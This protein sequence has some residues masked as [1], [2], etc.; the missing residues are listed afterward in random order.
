MQRQTRQ[1]SAII[2][3]LARVG[4]PL[5]ASEV[6]AAARSRAPGLG[7]ATVYR[8]LKRLVEEELIQA[9][10]L[11]GQ[12]G[13]FELAGKAHHHHF[14][15]RSCDSAFEVDGCPGNLERLTPPGFHLEKHEVLL[16]GLCQ[17]CAAMDV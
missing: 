15:C 6:L 17:D 4:R 9:V 10:V 1:R 8:Q 14:L 12:P 16:Y 11:P 3:A 13:R 2:E 7:Q 5:S